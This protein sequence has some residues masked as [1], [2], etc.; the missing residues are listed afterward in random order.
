MIERPEL[1]VVDPPRAGLHPKVVSQVLEL[2]PRRLV[3]VS[4][5]PSTQARDAALL[6][7]GGYLPRSLQAVDLFPHTYHVESVALFTAGS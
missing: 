3:Y 1:L 2:A 5:N 6:A 7:E 4:C